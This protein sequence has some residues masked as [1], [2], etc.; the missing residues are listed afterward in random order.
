M[1]N[2]K[3]TWCKVISW[4]KNNYRLKKWLFLRVNRTL[5]IET[6]TVSRLLLRKEWPFLRSSCRCIKIILDAKRSELFNKATILFNR[7]LQW[8]I[9]CVFIIKFKWRLT[10]SFCQNFPTSLVLSTLI[11]S[12]TQT[13]RHTED[14]WKK[15]MKLLVRKC[16]TAITLPVI[17]RII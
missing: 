17:T 15:L 11:N 3:W 4:W 2:S 5:N 9:Q 10:I 6:T 7:L 16:R 8:E 1:I 12:F 13:T 14:R